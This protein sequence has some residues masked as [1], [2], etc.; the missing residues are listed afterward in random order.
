MEAMVTRLLEQED[1]VRVVLSSD[2]KLSYLV[3]MWQDIDVL[4]S[5]S[6]ALSLISELTDFLSGEN[7]ITVSAVMPVSH[8]LKTKILLA[9]EDDTALTRDIKKIVF[10]DLHARYTDPSVL[11]LLSTATFIDPRFKT[12]YCEDKEDQLKS[13]LKSSCSREHSGITQAV[14]C[15][16]VTSSK[17]EEIVCLSKEG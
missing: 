4:E 16:T 2:R 13:R 11:K 6:K 14:Y 8:N 1:A 9:K 7:H 17:E 5:I 10:E 12:D 15:P 3:P